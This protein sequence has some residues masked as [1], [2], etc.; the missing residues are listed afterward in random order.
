VYQTIPNGHDRRS[1][2]LA[3]KEPLVNFL[4][5][6]LFLGFEKLRSVFLTYA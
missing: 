4:Y 3:P 6:G 2:L 5:M 1:K